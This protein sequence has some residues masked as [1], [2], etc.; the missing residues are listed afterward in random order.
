MTRHIVARVGE[1]PPGG[2]KRVAIAGREIALFRLEDAYFAIADRCP[3]EGASLCAGM[4]TGLAVSDGPGDYGLTR[5]GEILRCPWHGWEFDIRSGR[6]W[7]DPDRL[8]VRSFPTSTAH[9]ADLVRD[10]ETFP[11]TVENDYVLVEIASADLHDAV[12]AGRRLLA[13]RILLLELAHAGGGRLPDFLPGAHVD[14]HLG[15]GLVRPYSLCGE[16]MPDG[17]WRVAVLLEPASRGGSVAVHALRVGDGLRVGAP[18]ANFGLV[19]GA[20]A[21]C[22][23][24]GGIGITPLLGMAQRLA[25]LGEAFTLHY[26]V[27]AE[28]AAAFLPELRQPG[29]AP[30]LRLHDASAG[31]RLD[32]EA[33]LA[34]QPVAEVY[35]CGPARLLDAVAAAHARLGLPAARLHMERFNAAVAI[36]GAPFVVEAARSGLRLEVPADRSAAE[37]LVAAGI[38]V[39]LSCEQ[40]LCGSCL[41]PVLAGEP[42]HRDSVLSPAEQAAN[43][44]VALCCS[45][46]RGTLVLDI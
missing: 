41:T 36:G 45:R 28:A 6:S 15:A 8:R 3:H 9:G 12:V 4:L 23:I 42:E 20:R 13:D 29:I 27:R 33:A 17:H 44:V 22:L 46:A 18:R 2:R 32:I 39:P 30:S 26:C 14:L 40:G 24:A 37:V 43:R 5:E 10:A 25:R 1:V 35:V 7:C 21:H 34:A 16:P 11:V 38:A 31:Q 19:G